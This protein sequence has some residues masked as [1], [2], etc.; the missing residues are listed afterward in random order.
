M[1]AE[2]KKDTIGTD[3]GEVAREMIDKGAAVGREYTAAVGAATV[4]GL[5]T[6]FDIQSSFIAA[7]RSLADATVVANATLADKL[8]ETVKANQA[9][10]TKLAEA[11]TKLATETLEVRS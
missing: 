2:T 8:V 11:G 6:A 10:A 7:G 3:P 1:T 5:R 9:E 4:A